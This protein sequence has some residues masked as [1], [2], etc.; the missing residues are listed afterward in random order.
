M[1]KRLALYLVLALG[2]AAPALAEDAAWFVGGWR[3]NV[4]DAVKGEAAIELL[5]GNDGKYQRTYRPQAY[6]AMIHDSGTWVYQDGVLQLRWTEYTVIPEPMY[7]PL[8]K[9]TDTFF[10][11]PNGA[12]TFRFRSL[13][14]TDP[15]CWGTMH[16]AKLAQGAVGE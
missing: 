3:A 11:V 15:I 13:S 16:R 9:G 7:P 14:C 10:V 5:L 6:F 2:A 8:Q 12:D 1:L 4:I